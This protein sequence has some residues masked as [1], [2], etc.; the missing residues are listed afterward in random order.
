MIVHKSTCGLCKPHK[1]WK[2][3]RTKFKNILVK[4]VLEG[5]LSVSFVKSYQRKFDHSY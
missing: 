5:D 4:A 1:R 3:N 2:R